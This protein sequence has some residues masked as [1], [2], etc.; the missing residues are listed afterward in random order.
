MCKNHPARFWSCFPADL[1]Q[2][3][4]GSGMFT[5]D[6]PVFRKPDCLLTMHYGHFTEDLHV[7]FFHLVVCFSVVFMSTHVC[8]CCCCHFRFLF[9]FCLCLF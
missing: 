2:M 7:Q 6:V 5:G 4:I 1:D 3:Q 9:L 8:C